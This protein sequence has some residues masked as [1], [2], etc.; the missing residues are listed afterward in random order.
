MKDFSSVIEAEKV[1]SVENPA[2]VP[3]D[4]IAGESPGNNLGGIF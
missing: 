3:K 4:Y 1:F 2:G